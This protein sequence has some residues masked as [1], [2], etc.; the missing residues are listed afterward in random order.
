[1]TMATPPVVQCSAHYRE[2]GS[3]FGPTV[4][5]ENEAAFEVTCGIEETKTR[6]VPA[7]ETGGEPATEKYITFK[8]N[9]AGWSSHICKAHF[10]DTTIFN[11]SNYRFNGMTR[12]EAR[13]SL[14]LVGATV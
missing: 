7:T 11:L 1:M 12:E 8:P 6:L 5:C 13:E 3:W 2:Q 4:R 14:Q 10:H 9:P